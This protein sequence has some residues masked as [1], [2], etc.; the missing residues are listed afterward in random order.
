MFEATQ[1]I[2]IGQ[3]KCFYRERLFLIPQDILFMAHHI[4]LDD[5]I[6][7]QFTIN[8]FRAPKC[9]FIPILQ[10]SNTQIARGL[11]VIIIPIFMLSLL[12]STDKNILSYFVRVNLY[13]ISTTDLMQKVKVSGATQNFTGDSTLFLLCKEREGVL[14]ITE[15]AK[16][17]RLDK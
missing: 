7:G 15:S 14:L 10:K 12:L 8:V 13:R 11:C 9:N 3:V 5:H 4:T 16:T 17:M 1:G 6:L 2:T